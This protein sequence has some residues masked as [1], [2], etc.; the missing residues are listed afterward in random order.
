[1]TQASIFKSNRSQAVRL[2]KH[3]ALPEGVEKVEIYCL[4]HA[5]L[6]VPAGRTWE[7]F[8]D[9]P[10]VSDDFMA[11]RSQPPAQEREVF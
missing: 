5:R 9:G 2:P 3:M 4:G 1:M 8:F 10:P 7:D 6:I 11:Q